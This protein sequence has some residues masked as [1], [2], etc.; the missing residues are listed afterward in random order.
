MRNGVEDPPGV[1]AF[2]A[3]PPEDAARVLLEQHPQ[4][5]AERQLVVPGA[6]HLAADREHLRAGRLLG[7]DLLEPVGAVADDVRDVHQRLDVVDDGRRGVQTLDGRERRAQA[8]LAAEALERA[9]QRRLLAADVRAGAAVQHDVEVVPAAEHVG[10]EQPRRVRLV[11]RALQDPPLP[12]VLA[13]D[14]DE[15]GVALDRARGDRGPLDQRVR[16]SLDELA[17][18][19]GPRLGFVEVHHH[20]RGL[21]GVHRHERPLHAGGEAGAAAPAQAGV[22]HE[23]RSGRRPASRAPTATPR[24]RRC[25]GSPRG[26]SRPGRPSAPSAPCGPQSRA[27]SGSRPARIREASLKLPTAGPR[28]GSGTRPSRS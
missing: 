22:L 8:R 23:L 20:V 24:S 7:A 28:L 26:R 10:A 3:R 4:R 18:V 5:R 17:V 16:L 13:A 9:E 25:A 27:P 19:A 15:R 21:A 1:H 12:Q 6:L 2:R 14:V 11:Q